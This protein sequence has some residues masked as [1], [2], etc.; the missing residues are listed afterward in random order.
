MSISSKEGSENPKK[1][2]TVEEEDETI[3]TE[4]AEKELST[5]AESR[6]PMKNGRHPSSSPTTPS[7]KPSSSGQLSSLKSPNMKPKVATAGKSPKTPRGSRSSSTSQRSKRAS[8]DAKKKGIT[9]KKTVGVHT[10]PNLDTYSNLEKELTWYAP[11]DYGAMEDECDLTAELLDR[12]K[13][14]WPGQCPRGLE[15]WTTEGEQRK[16]G[17]VQLAIDIVWQAQIEQWKASSDVSECWEFIRSRYLAVSTP[18]HRLANKRGLTDETEVQPYLAGVR[19]VER[20]RLR[21]LGIHQ[22]SST[23]GNRRAR[24]TNGE[25]SATA[26]QTPRSASS[27]K[28]IGRTFSEVGTQG[29]NG[30]SPPSRYHS[31]DNIKVPKKGLLKVSDE[32][33]AAAAAATPVAGGK[34]KKKSASDANDQD[35]DVSQTSSKRSGA[36][37]RK[38]SYQPKS[39][40]KVPVSPVGSLVT[41]ASD[42]DSTT[43]RLRSHMSV[44]S[45]DSTRRRM[46]R[47]ASIKPPL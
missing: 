34:I 37:G 19:S 24:P 35:D 31:S 15:A 22:R 23:V 41:D 33:A 20:N 39:R 7:K 46:L 47:T 9:F 12:R 44:S 28:K 36:S 38:I 17:H 43:R 45:E 32:D 16:E 11:D 5:G 13:P 30:K 1:E 2:L 4:D 26:E 40:S 21:L 25:T 6:S 18:C 27:K 29:T 42:G 10:I 14:L 8:S 3:I